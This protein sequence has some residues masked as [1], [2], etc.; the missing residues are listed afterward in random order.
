M[1]NSNNLKIL[2]V[3][4]LAFILVFGLFLFSDKAFARTLEY[5]HGTYDKTLHYNNPLT[6]NYVGCYNSWA[7][8]CADSSCTNDY[9]PFSVSDLPDR[10]IT[11]AG[12]GYW[13]WDDQLTTSVYLIGWGTPIYSATQP[14][15]VS[16]GAGSA[17]NQNPAFQTFFSNDPDTGAI[18]YYPTLAY[19]V[20]IPSFS[21]FRQIDMHVAANERHPDSPSEV[22][23]DYYL[24]RTICDANEKAEDGKCV[25]ITGK[26]YLNGSLDNITCATAGSCSVVVSWESNSYQKVDLY[27]NWANLWPGKAP[28]GSITET[29]TNSGSS[30]LTFSYCLDG[31]GG[32]GVLVPDLSCNRN[33]TVNPASTP[34]IGAK[35]TE[36]GTDTITK[37][38]TPGQNSTGPIDFIYWNDGQTGSTLYVTG[39]A[40]K[41]TSKIDLS[42][43]TL[44][45]CS[46]TF[47]K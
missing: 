4:A 18:T 31:Y 33:V 6:G 21:G 20:N 46:G 11:W 27:K 5:V 24:G 14:T 8:S 43:V 34:A 39:C 45:P 15:S 1:N 2:K 36:S 30:P 42:K 40:I 35:W 26:I 10:V 7:T 47:P 16:C 25:D 13:S 38:L 3:F 44:P 37:T 17:S 32:G 23:I 9:A 12:R 22:V 28:S 19:P 41:S 29:L